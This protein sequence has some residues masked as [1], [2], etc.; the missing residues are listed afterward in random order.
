MVQLTRSS[1]HPRR[2]RVTEN[3]RQVVHKSPNHNSLI[4]Q[5]PRRRFCNDGVADRSDGNHLAES[6]NHQ[7]DA[8]GQLC[9][10]VALCEAKT[11]NDH[12]TSKHER[13]PA[14]VD[15]CA[16]EVREE[17]PADDAADDVACGKG[18][19]DIEGLQLRKPSR[20]EKNDR[21]PEDGIAAEGLSRPDDAILVD[22]LA[23]GAV[24]HSNER[25]YNFRSPQVRPLEAFQETCIFRLRLLQL[26]GMLDVRQRRLDLSLFVRCVLSQAS[27][28]LSR[29]VD[30]APSDGI[31]RRLR[32]QV[33]SDKQG[34]RP[35]PLQNKR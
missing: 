31:P 6:A 33:R 28:A 13:Q 35:D 18:D 5:S 26:G 3:T 16:S 21:V 19:V 29:Q 14:H 20:F 12:H 25:M 1:N 23:L 2:K 32:S 24:G 15:G 7:E 17:K 34:D 4:S 27:Q 10:L 30:L 22:W 9:A 11:A 8:D